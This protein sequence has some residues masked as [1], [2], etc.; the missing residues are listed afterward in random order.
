MKVLKFGGTSVGNS[1]NIR[2][3][4]D[5]MFCQKNSVVVFSAM[6]GTTNN[7]V[8]I[9][10]C[11]KQNK[12]IK[13][14]I[15]NEIKKYKQVA[16]ELINNEEIYNKVEKFIIN[17]YSKIIKITANEFSDQQENLIL[18]KG[19]EITC[20]MIYHY[21]KSENIACELLWSPDF[22]KINEEGEPDQYYIRKKINEKLK[23][24]KDT[25]FVVQG[26]ICSDINGAICN[27]Q[28]GGSD[29]TASLIGAAINAE[30]IQIWTDIDGM[31]NNDP[32]YVNPTKSISHLSFKEAAELAYFGAKILH[33]TSILPAC[34]Q[35]IPV[36]L[37]NTMNPSA[38]GTLITNKVV[39][40]G[41]KAV[42]AKDNITCI[43]IES[44]RMLMAYG[45]LTKVF[46][47]FERFKTPIDMITTS[48]VAVAVTIDDCSKLG[49]IID[50]LL[51]LGNV[52][53]I[54]DQSIISVVGDLIAEKCGYANKIF[55]TLKNV[56][57]RMISY[58]A[59]NN[60]VSLLINSEYKVQAL[61]EINKIFV[62]ES[63][64]V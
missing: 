48:E 37:K 60:N 56:P 16:K 35:N 45:F 25:V 36:R 2:I 6:S 58:G 20:F 51:T 29:Y 28:R 44:D 21:F 26:Y 55:D 4:R 43:R 54:K 1:N 7:L 3:I 13:T 33:P 63:S 24:L 57:I 22:I 18:S 31:H 19:E 5:I 40:K 59:S 8:E 42:A 12:C 23:N 14:L 39:V 11:I 50:K 10:S 46:E 15:N 62:H 41:I 47:I 9:C 32:R 38:E 53:I 27:L 64:L 34:K 30:E 49:G 61:N 17:E 52:E